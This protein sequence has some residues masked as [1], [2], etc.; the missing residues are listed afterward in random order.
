MNDRICD[1][2]QST[3]RIL[4]V[5]VHSMRTDTRTSDPDVRISSTLNTE[6]YAQLPCLRRIPKPHSLRPEVR[7]HE[8]EA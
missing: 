7:I 6:A 2:L 1:L 4:R 5:S 8:T 3:S